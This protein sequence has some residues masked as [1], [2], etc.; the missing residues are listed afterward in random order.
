MES[1]SS[2]A[3]PSTVASSRVHRTTSSRSR[4][5]RRGARHA[6][7]PVSAS[8]VPTAVP[9]GS[10][11]S[12][13]ST[14]RRSRGA[15]GRRGPSDS[16]AIGRPASSRV[17]TS[18]G[19]RGRSSQARASAAHFC[20]G[21]PAAQTSA[22]VVG[23]QS[24]ATP[25]LSPTRSAATATSTSSAA[26]VS[27]AS[28][29]RATRRS[30]RT[31]RPPE[32]SAGG[33]VVAQNATSCSTWRSV[34]SAAPA[35]VPSTVPTPRSTVARSG[36]SRASAPSGRSPR[37]ASPT[38]RG[39]STVSGS[40]RTSSPRDSSRE[41]GFAGPAPP[42]APDRR[43]G[44]QRLEHPPLV[45][46]DAGEQLRK[47]G[48]RGDPRRGSA[49]AAGEAG[50]DVADRRDER[51]PGPLGAGRVG[52]DRV[53]R[54]RARSQRG[55]RSVEDGRG[56]S[57]PSSRRTSSRATGRGVRVRDD[58]RLDD[59]E[60]D[61]VEVVARPVHRG[62]DA[63]P[64]GQHGQVGGRGHGEVRPQPEQVGQRVVVLGTQPVDQRGGHRPP[65]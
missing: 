3:T 30:S 55:E 35:A 18:P 57:G 32:R 23:T 42:A 49:E 10:S 29:S 43:P 47:G 46:V 14:R 37:S 51:D 21:P 48:R 6:S 26:V 17:P 31:P 33:G 2:A 41:T 60:G 52:V 38:W 7:R 34:R 25:S 15:V 5:P 36:G 63:G 56:R 59:V 54:Q 45:R 1:A 28:T 53:P 61:R 12:P 9:G 44:R 27:S 13:A 50:D 19:T 4:P 62:A 65:R 58:E 16:A 40:T 20:S 8:G 22:V 64:G 11:A 24:G 39:N